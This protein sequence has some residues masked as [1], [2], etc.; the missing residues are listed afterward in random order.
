MHVRSRTVVRLI[1]AMLVLFVVSGSVSTAQQPLVQIQIPQIE[2][3]ALVALYESTDGANWE[4]PWLLH[5]DTPC[6]L[7]GVY[8]TD[9]H[10]TML[11]LNDRQLNGTIPPE[12]ADLAFL[13]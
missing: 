11:E 2:Y 6:A 13:S 9:G 12:I 10:V 4:R 8:C 5:T 3:D 1:L 7:E